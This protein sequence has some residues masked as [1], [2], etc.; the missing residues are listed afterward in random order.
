MKIVDLHE[1]DFD[2][3]PSGSLER[4]RTQLNGLSHET[5]MLR[6]QLFN[7]CN[8]YNIRLVTWVTSVPVNSPKL[9]FR[10]FDTKGVNKQIVGDFKDK[11]IPPNVL[12]KMQSIVKKLN[13]V[14]HHQLD[15]FSE[16]SD[17]DIRP[18]SYSIA[19][20]WQLK[21]DRF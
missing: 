6:E 7:I 13:V 15:L 20:G 21:H 18:D 19:N 14:Y 5:W 9:N 3:G 10:T 4:I 12:S 11:V 16:L 8:T 2:N 1:S 17:A